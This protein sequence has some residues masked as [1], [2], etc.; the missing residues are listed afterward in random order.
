MFF[1]DVLFDCVL[2]FSYCSVIYEVGFDYIGYFGFIFYCFCDWDWICVFFDGGRRV[3]RFYFFRIFG[4]FGGFGF[5]LFEYGDG[6]FIDVYLELFIVLCCG[7]YV[8][9][10][11]FVWFDCYV[12]FGEM[13]YDFRRRFVRVDVKRSV[14]FIY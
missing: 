8:F 3:F 4:R 10:Y 11:V 7:I 12:C 5:S 14:V 2:E 13:R 6:D 9:G 1:G